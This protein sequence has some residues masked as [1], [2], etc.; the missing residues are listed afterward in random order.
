LLPSRLVQWGVGV[1]L[2]AVVTVPVGLAV[3]H[4]DDRRGHADTLARAW[5][6]D[7]TAKPAW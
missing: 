1:A 6:W 7:S 2:E 3:T 4:Q 5:T